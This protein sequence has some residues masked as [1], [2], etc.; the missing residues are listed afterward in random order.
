MGGCAQG[1]PRYLQGDDV[2]SPEME[3]DGVQ[4]GWQRHPLSLAVDGRLEGCRR[5]RQEAAKGPNW[6][7][8]GVARHEECVAAPSPVLSLGG[9]RAPGEAPEVRQSQ[10]GCDSGAEPWPLG[11]NRV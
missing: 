5:W 10:A 4:G 11:G 9:G 3:I 1:S 7:L 8:E 2:P 6:H